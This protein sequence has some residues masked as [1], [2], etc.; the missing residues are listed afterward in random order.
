MKP[1]AYEFEKLNFHK[2]NHYIFQ[3]VKGRKLT[4]VYHTHDFYE[5]IWFVRGNGTHMI[6]DTEIPCKENSVFL[7]RPKDTHC[8]TAQSDDAVVISLSVEKTEFELFSSMYHIGLADHISKSTVPIF[9]DFSYSMPMN[10][11]VAEERYISE[12]DCKFLLSCL[13]K[14]YID[15]TNYKARNT[16]LPD[17]LANSIEEMKKPENLRRGISA[18]T[19]LSHYSQSHLARLIQKHFHTTLKQYINVLRL[20]QAYRDILLTNQSTAE[21]AE[22]LGYSSL[23]HFNKIFKEAF[24]VTPSALRKQ[25]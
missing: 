24:S 19:E 2:R 13:L 21:I 14:K 7:L 5:A 17:K 25:A 4:S 3:L 15:N 16:E 6:N 12:Y 22:G 1:I 11:Y 9:Y 23:S 18:F 8:F 10:S 20:Q